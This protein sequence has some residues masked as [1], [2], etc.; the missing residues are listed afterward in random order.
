VFFS[1]NILKFYKSP[2][3]Q[4]L[5]QSGHRARR[6]PKV[7]IGAFGWSK[8]KNKKK[9]SSYEFFSVTGFR[10]RPSGFSHVGLDQ[11]CQIFLATIYQQGDKYAKLPPNIPN[12]HK[13]CL[14]NV[15]KIDQIC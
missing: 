8:V 10:F 3:G 1:K 6:L 15:R 5:A 2:K 9:T 7:L 14:S 12:I 13:I 11:G 4:K